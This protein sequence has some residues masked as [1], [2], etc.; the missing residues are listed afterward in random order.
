MQGRVHGL[1]VLRQAIT[2]AY[3]EERIPEAFGT[4]KTLIVIGDGYGTFASLALAAFPGTRVVTINLV[5]T[6]LVDLIYTARSL[7]GIRSALATDAASVRHA[8]SDRKIGVI[9]LRA[10][11]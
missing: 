10:D 2:L 5:K 4:E 7:P 1:D 11:D 9:A 3:P 8:V 6:L